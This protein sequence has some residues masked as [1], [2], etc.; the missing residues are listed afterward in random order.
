MIEL[1]RLG[2]SRTQIAA[3]LDVDRDT[4]ANWER[5]HPEFFGAMRRAR[6]LA[7]AWWED[8]GQKG[9]WERGFNA[10]AYR[11]QVTN[12]FPDEWRDKRSH[13]HTG[14]DGTALVPEPSDRE[15]AKAIVGILAVARIEHDERLRDTG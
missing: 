5:A 8:E 14:T 2:K 7:L 3:E 11:L 12:R 1:G 10:N 13:E 6:E 9:V 15:L 4:L